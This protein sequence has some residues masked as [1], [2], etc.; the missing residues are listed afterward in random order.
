MFDFTKPV[1][2]QALLNAMVQNQ[3]ANA[4]PPAQQGDGQQPQSIWSVMH[5][6]AGQGTQPTALFGKNGM[7]GGQGKGGAKTP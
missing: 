3:M 2:F 7:F 5:P 4:P 6:N 1:S